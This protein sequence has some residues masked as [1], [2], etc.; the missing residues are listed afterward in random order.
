MT[1]RPR[2]R[3]LRSVLVGGTLFCGL[4]IVAE[5]AT[6]QLGL[7]DFPLYEANAD[8]GYVPKPNQQGAFLNKNDWQFNSRSMGAPEFEPGPGPNVLLVGDSIVDGGNP[9]RQQER[10]GPLTQKALA[11]SGVKV[12]PIAAGSWSLRNELKWLQRNPDVV[13]RVDEVVFLLGSNDFGDASSWSCEF[14]HP[15]SHP[16]SSLWFLFNKYVYRLEPCGTPPDALKVPQG[17][18]HA[19]LERFMSAFGKKTTVVLYATAEESRNPAERARSFE[20][21]RQL[22]RSVGVRDPVVIADDARWS[23]DCYKDSVHP[24]PSAMPVLADILAPH[25]LARVGAPKQ[26]AW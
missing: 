20:P 15:R 18:V 8:I 22:L 19:E 12:W 21:A 9:Y 24:K 17:D 5:I 7:L 3:L 4:L 11:P 6:R 1:Q 25:I 2:S 23:P 14:S 16:T 10:L 26:S 13:D